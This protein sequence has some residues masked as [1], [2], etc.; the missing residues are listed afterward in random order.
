MTRR[1]DRRAELAVRLAPWWGSLFLCAAPC[2][3]A[4]DVAERWQALFAAVPALP[5]TPSEAS[6]M[7]SARLVHSEGLGIRQVRIGVADAGLRGFQQDVDRLFDS[8]AKVS[9]E[10]IQRTMD[11]INNDPVLAEW[12]RRLDKAWQPDPTHPDKLPSPE[13]F[14][15]LKREVEEFLGP[16]PAPGSAA[17]APQSE[18]AAYRLEL[19]R[20]TPAA[21][22][23]LE[24]LTALQRQYAQQH[25]QADRETV[26]R[27]AGADVAAAAH[28]L[29]ARHHALA[30][31]Q[32]A[33]A[34][35]ILREARDAMAPRVLHLVELASAAEQRNAPPA[36]RNS[37]YALL[38]SYVEFLLTLE[39]E[40][41][42]D[43]GFWGGMRVSSALPAPAQ[44]GTRSLYEQALAPGFELRANG[45]LP[46]S[47]PYYPS[48][49]AIVVGLPPGIQ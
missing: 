18:I 4:A 40:T 36:E 25:M 14:R 43:V 3:L 45:E 44:A 8:T 21:S 39:R 17:P 9:A 10:Q 22:Q 13:E 30:Q 48:G 28:A 2:A 47:L 16:M 24:R 46:H 34:S 32:L 33:D 1:F 7:I 12:A 19:R 15:A 35:A 41:L 31:Q 26:A 27:L 20:A 42:Q 38:K 29:V 5:A 37:A 49:R 6:R 23:F 11:A